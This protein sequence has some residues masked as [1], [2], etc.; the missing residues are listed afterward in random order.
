MPRSLGEDLGSRSWAKMDIK[1]VCIINIRPLLNH[2]R[3]SEPTKTQV[4]ELIS[5]VNKIIKRVF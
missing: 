4:D 5:G 3:N 2:A 1:E